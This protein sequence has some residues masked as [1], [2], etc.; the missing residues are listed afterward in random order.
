[1]VGYDNIT[2]SAYSNPTLSSI[3]Q[4]RQA[5]GQALVDRLF[6]LIEDGKANNTIID[7]KRVV[8]E[9]ST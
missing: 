6:E 7:T 4:D 9:S 2:L 3:S 8:R 1:M 5:G